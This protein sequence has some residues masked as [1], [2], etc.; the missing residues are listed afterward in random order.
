MAGINVADIYEKEKQ[1]VYEAYKLL[2]QKRRSYGW[3]RFIVFILMVLA[4]WKVFTIAGYV[5]FIPLVIG[6]AILLFFGFKGCRQQ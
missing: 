5:G 2:I 6:L 1:K 3:L 4:T